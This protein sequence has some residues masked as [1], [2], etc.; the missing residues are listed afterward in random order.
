MNPH[1]EKETPSATRQPVTNRVLYGSLSFVVVVALAI[2]LGVGFGRKSDSSDTSAI[3]GPTVSPISP[4]PTASTRDL[5][6]S[7]NFSDSI[8]F[9]IFK[10]RTDTEQYTAVVTST[11]VSLD[12]YTICFTNNLY[13]FQQ[14][15]SGITVEPEIGGTPTSTDCF[16]PENLETVRPQ[17]YGAVVLLDPENEIVSSL[18]YLPAAQESI[19]ATNRAILVS[20]TDVYNIT[21]TIWVRGEVAFNSFTG[22]ATD[23]RILE[24]QDI[25]MVPMPPSLFLYITNR[26]AWMAHDPEEDAFIYIHSSDDSSLEY[27]PGSFFEE[28]TYHQ[29]W[30][31]AVNATHFARGNFYLWCDVFTITLAGGALAEYTL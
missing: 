24:F 3:A 30:D 18:F 26:D 13:V 19:Y 14:S 7:A 29:D 2:G 8:S 25:R 22:E 4:S 1:E 16:G 28:G 9:G 20:V 31:E 21:G 23:K 5:Q 27:P 10:E 6:Y 11:D 15:L 12:S 17:D